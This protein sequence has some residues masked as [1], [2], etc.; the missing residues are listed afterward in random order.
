[1]S[2]SRDRSEPRTVVDIPEQT[3]SERILELAEPLLE[4]RDSGSD[5][6]AVRDAVA[7][8][9]AFW[10]AKAQAS[11]FWGSCRTK[12][13]DDLRRRMTGKKA[14]V[15]DAEAF[16]VL[17]DLWSERRFAF[18]PRLVGEWSFAIGEDGHLLLSCEAE[19]PD[20]VEAAVPPPV[21]KRVAIGGRF[22]DEAGIRAP[23]PPGAVLRLRF[24]CERHRGVVGDDGRITI[25]TMMPT[26]VALFAEGVIPPTGGGVVDLDVGAAKFREM[27]LTEV[28]CESGGGHNDVAVLVFEPAASVAA[29]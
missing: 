12:K 6:E 11:K 18:D 9:V 25:H 16:A 14:A 23:G 3:L 19:L 26:A 21:E 15:E 4:R 20:G 7:L 17:S 5:P 8:A 28:R 13:L 2:E 29:P 1:M 24:P 22:L 27:V 10:N